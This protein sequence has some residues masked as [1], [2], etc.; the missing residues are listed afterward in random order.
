MDTI[1]TETL[2]RVS[3]KWPL[4]KLKFLYKRL[5]LYAVLHKSRIMHASSNFNI[6][7]EKAT[8]YGG[9]IA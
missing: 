6:N 1:E 9:F 5:W 3:V 8:R 4:V 7:I 2:I